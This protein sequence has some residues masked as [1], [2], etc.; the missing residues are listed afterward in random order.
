MSSTPEH[1]TRRGVVLTLAVLLAAGMPRADTAAAT[2]WPTRAATPASDPDAPDWVAVAGL[3]LRRQDGI[4]GL[5]SVLRLEAPERLLFASD[6]GFWLEAEPRWDDSGALIGLGEARRHAEI[7]PPSWS[8]DIEGMARV[9]EDLWI[10]TERVSHRPD[11]VIRLDGV[12]LPAP[13]VE[14]IDLRQLNLG[15]NR[16]A[17]ALVDLPGGGWL[18]VTET[19]RDG[20]FVAFDH[21]G[22]VHRYLADDGFAPTGADRLGERILL[23]ERSLGLFGGW[24]ARVVCLT[25]DDLRSSGDLRP[26]PLAV[27]GA[28]GAIDNMEGIAVWPR[29]DDVEVLLVSDDNFAAPQRT[30][31]LHYRWLGGASGGCRPGPHQQAEG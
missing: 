10:A 11:R 4:G 12:R 18:A 16:G 26:V 27:L 14:S 8:S 6:R 17:E 30:L 7:L 24:R 9:A 13:V 15:A 25:V 28:P 31:L 3:E 29:G 5:S 20:G 1:A 19:R 22:H 23:V 2:E 21:T